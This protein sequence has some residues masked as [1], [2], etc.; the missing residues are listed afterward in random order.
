MH[1]SSHIVLLVD[2]S[3]FEIRIVGSVALFLAC[4]VLEWVRPVGE[5]HSIM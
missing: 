5:A 1:G 4:I 2:H 3:F